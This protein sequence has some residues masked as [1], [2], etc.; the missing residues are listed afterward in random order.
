MRT[1]I[2]DR[3]SVSTRI[4]AAILVQQRLARPHVTV[5]LVNMN[6]R[7]L[8]KFILNRSVPISYN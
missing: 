7:V 2:I 3:M 1:M 8:R 5:G 6:Q 4:G